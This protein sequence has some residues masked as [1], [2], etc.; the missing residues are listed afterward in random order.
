MTNKKNTV[1]FL[2][3]GATKGSGFTKGSETKGNDQGLP[4]DQQFFKKGNEEEE[5][6]VPNIIPNWEKGYPALS[7]CRELIPGI[8]SDSLCQTWNQLFI[9]RSLARASLYNDKSLIEH[10]EKLKNHNWL[11]NFK[12]REKHYSWQFKIINHS[13]N[14]LY[15]LAELAIWD[16]RALV[17]EIYSDLEDPQSPYNTLKGK[18]GDNLENWIVVNLNYDTTFDDCFEDKFSPLNEKD[19]L[20]NDLRKKIIRPHGSLKWTSKN[21][22]SEINNT[23]VNPDWEETFDDTN[24]TNQGYQETSNPE[25]LIFHQSLI[26]PPADFKEEIIG[27]STLPGLM[28]QLL[29]NQWRH[30]EMALEQSNKIIFYGTSLASGDNHLCFLIRKNIKNKKILIFDTNNTESF[31]N[32][33]KERFP[34]ANVKDIKFEDIPKQKV[35]TPLES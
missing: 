18:I 26:V 11:D 31:K 29:W 20:V 32:K 25:Q 9:F 7:L 8:T 10:F 30:M 6:G 24:L 34:E 17:K 15:Y 1:L 27:N 22:F 28:S 14:P 4:T 2:G 21:W 23:W 35:V 16:L 13:E 33:W 3:S 5:G 12:W 19:I